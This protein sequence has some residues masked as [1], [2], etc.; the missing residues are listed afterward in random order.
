MD[1]DFGGNTFVKT[2]M[3]V[4]SNIEVIH[5]PCFEHHLTTYFRCMV[6]EQYP[7]AKGTEGTSFRQE[8]NKFDAGANYS[9]LKADPWVRKSDM[10]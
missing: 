3:D 10:S 9:F 4:P 7:Q 2:L 8:R 1:Y 6:M 5:V